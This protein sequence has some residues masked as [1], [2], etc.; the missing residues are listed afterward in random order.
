MTINKVAKSNGNTTWTI[1]INGEI[2]GL[3]VKNTSSRTPQPWK[4]YKGIGM[5]AKMVGY[6]FE[7]IDAATLLVVA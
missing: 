2:V 4:A 3:I 5:D 6:T 1:E 7:S